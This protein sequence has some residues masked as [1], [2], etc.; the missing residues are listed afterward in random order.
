MDALS[1][2]PSG[3]IL[4]TDVTVLRTGLNTIKG[5]AT[6][7]LNNNGAK[8]EDL[9]AALNRILEEAESTLWEAADAS[10]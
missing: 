2:T 9:R 8:P 1:L 10:P 6:A 7:C 5:F 3:D 4:R